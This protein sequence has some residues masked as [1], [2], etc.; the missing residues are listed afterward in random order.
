[1][2]K[3]SGALGKV[4]EVGRLGERR[5]A[6]ESLVQIKVVVWIPTHSLLSCFKFSWRVRSFYRNENSSY[7]NTKNQKSS[8]HLF[9]LI[10]RILA[11]A[12]VEQNQTIT[13]P[14]DIWLCGV[15]SAPRSPLFFSKTP[16]SFH[17]MIDIRESIFSIWK[18]GWLFKCSMDMTHVFKC[19]NANLNGHDARVQM[20]ECKFKWTWRTC[21]E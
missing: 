21:F 1:M 18:W 5:R 8:S 3:C 4:A 9:V 14:R 10:F 13:K 17:P 16:F 12:F 15:N 2:I 20:F 11:R 7:R 6:H 19:S